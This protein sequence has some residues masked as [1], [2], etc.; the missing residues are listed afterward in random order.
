MKR[1]LIMP[2][3]LT[4]LTRRKSNWAALVIAVA[5]P[6]CTPANCLAQSFQDWYP[7]SI[8]PPAGHQYPCAL[9]ALPKSLTGIPEADRRFINHVYAMLLQCVGAK[10]VMIDTLMQDHQAYASTFTRY[11]TET[12]AARKKIVSE[13]TPAGLEDFKNTVV[14]AIDEQ[15]RFFNKA[16]RDRQ[17]GQ[18]AQQVLAL[19]EGKKASSM[20]LQAWSLMT[21]RYPGMSAQVKDSTYHHLCALDLF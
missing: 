3:Q 9:T 4:S 5:M 14:A 15:I 8:S 2:K 11:Y 16:V 13:P 12:V 1:G 19:P 6:L 18:S 10:V 7:N 21:A 20:L 17:A